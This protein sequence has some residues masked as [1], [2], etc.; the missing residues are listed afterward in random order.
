MSSTMIRL[1]VLCQCVL[2]GCLRFRFGNN[3][4]SRE[5][6]SHIVSVCFVRLF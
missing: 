4:I 6:A 1:L 2:C 3:E 5:T